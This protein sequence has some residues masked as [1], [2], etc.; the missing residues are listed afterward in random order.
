MNLTNN[1][2]LEKLKFLELDLANSDSLE[3]LSHAAHLQ[4]I[5]QDKWKLN[6]SDKDEVLMVHKIDYLLN[7][8]RFQ[9]CAT[10]R[11]IGEGGAHTAMAKTVGLPLALGAI[12]ILDGSI[13][14]R[15]CLMPFNVHWGKQILLHLEELGIQFVEATQQINN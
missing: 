13:G 14:E 5:L 12:A 2:I 6:D 3:N 4:N 7:D 1:H 15:G 9:Y 10:L 11:I 8:N